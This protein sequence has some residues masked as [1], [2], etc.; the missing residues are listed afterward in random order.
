MTR[1]PKELILGGVRSGKSRLAQ[2]LAEESA[3]PVSYLATARIGDAGM[4]QRVEQ[5]RRHR[6][7]HWDLVE[8]PL[9]LADA[10]GRTARPGRCLIVDCLTLWLTQLLCETG[11]ARL[12]EETTA[13]L[14]ALPELPGRIILI[15]NETSM[16]VLPPDELSRRYCDEAGNLHQALAGLCDRVVLTVAGLPLVLKGEPL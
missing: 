3:M 13:L 2:R 4:A 14:D 1:S 10:L 7:A 12:T 11:D 16:G 8:E 15:G 5:H 9:A 6:P